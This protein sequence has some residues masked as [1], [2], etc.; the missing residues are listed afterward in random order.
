M[1]GLGGDVVGQRVHARRDAF[2][3]PALVRLIGLHGDAQGLVQTD[4]LRAEEG[5]VLGRV[6]LIEGLVRDV[7]ARGDLRD[8]QAGKALLGDDRRRR[9]DDP[10]ALAFDDQIARQVVAPARQAPFGATAALRRLL[11]GLHV[12]ARAHVRRPLQP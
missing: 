1:H 11:G 5:I 12:V 9:V 4:L 2:M 7:R 10:F 6:H 8:R 3:P